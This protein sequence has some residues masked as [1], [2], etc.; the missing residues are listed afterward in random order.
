MDSAHDRLRRFLD[1]APYGAVKRLAEACGVSRQAV[2]MWRSGV[3]PSAKYFT[4]IHRVT[5]IEPT[6]WFAA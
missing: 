2:H 3:T 6:A 4:A 1:A 5:G